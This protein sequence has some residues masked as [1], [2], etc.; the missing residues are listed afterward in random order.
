MTFIPFKNPAEADLIVDPLLLSLTLNGI[1]FNFDFVQ[2]SI[3]G[4]F[5]VVHTDLT[6]YRAISFDSPLIGDD[7]FKLALVAE[8]WQ[9]NLSLAFDL[10]GLQWY[11][12]GLMCA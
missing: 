9:N 5:Q 11:W 3:F 2:T 4:I 12:V 1:S 7:R 10:R 6:K 8:S